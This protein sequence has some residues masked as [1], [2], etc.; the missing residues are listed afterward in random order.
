MRTIVDFH[1]HSRYSRATSKDLDLQEIAKWAKIKGIDVVSCADFTHPR[2]FHELEQKLVQEDSGLLTMPGEDH[3]KFIVATEVA[4]IYNHRGAVRRLHHLILAPSLAVAKRINAMLERR[5]CKLA[6]DGRPIL[7]LSSK[8]LLQIVLEADPR[9]ALIPAHA[10]TPWFAIFGSKSG[11]DSVDECFEELT[12]HIFA[13]ETGLSSDPEMNWSLSKLDRYALVS[14]SDA[15]SG[16]KLGR[17]ANVFDMKEVTYDALIE[18]IQVKDPKRFLYTIEFFPEEGMYHYDGHRLCGVRLEPS[19]TKREKGICSVCKRPLTVGVLNRVDTLRDRSFGERPSGA[20]P[21]K[22]IVPL[23]EIIGD[24]F[25]TAESSKKVMEFYFDIIR[26][27]GNEFR[28]LLDLDHKDLVQIMPE[29]LADGV[30]RVREGKVSIMPGYDGKY[31]IV[32]LFSEADRK[33][34]Q[35]ASLW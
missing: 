27:A 35:Q 16:P 5:G 10:W 6:A 9:C 8:E 20:I 21:F 13:L 26:K 29:A 2:W 30:L 31:G 15:H 12:P 14:N 3:L 24:Y 7:G 17:E 23:P 22:K 34:K 32:N 18:S 33:V 19:Q 25:Q 28:V 4:C 1:I 11:Y